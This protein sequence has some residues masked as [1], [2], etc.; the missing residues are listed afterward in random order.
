MAARDFL[1]DDRASRPA[2]LAVVVGAHLAAFFIELPDERV[3]DSRYWYTP[4]SIVPPPPQPSDRRPLPPLTV[5]P[6][7][8]AITSPPPPGLAPMDLPSEPSAPTGSATALPDWKQSGADAAADAAGKSYRALGPRPIDP[9]V[10]APRSPFKPP[11]KHKLGELGEDALENPVLWLS[12]N[13]YVRF[14][15]RKAPPGDPFAN[16]PMTLCTFPLGKLEPRGDL[17]E[18]LRKPQP[19]P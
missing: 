14:E 16:I 19:L 4:T 12:E 11:P 8:N 17:F 15:N 7:T 13:C 2:I 1:Y 18:H 5:A 3:T 9:Q 10:K 6:F